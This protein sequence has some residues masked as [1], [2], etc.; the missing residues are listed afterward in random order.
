MKIDDLNLGE[1]DRHDYGKTFTGTSVLKPDDDSNAAI[2]AKAL[3]R[4]AE[5]EMLTGPERS[6]LSEYIELFVTMITDAGLRSRLK[7]MQTTIKKNSSSKDDSK[8]DK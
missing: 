6:A 5:G 7:D 1:K 8:E 3:I 2:A 4:A